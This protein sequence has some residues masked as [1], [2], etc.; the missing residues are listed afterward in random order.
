LDDLEFVTRMGDL[1]DR[2]GMDTISLSNTIG[3]AITLFERGIIDIRD[4]SGL[5]LDWGHKDTG[6]KLVH[7]T[8]RL[9]GFGKFISEGARSLGRRFAAE[10]EAIQVNGLEVAYHDPRGSSGMAL[11]YATSPRGACHN[12][13]DYF[14]VDIGQVEESLDLELYN[15]LAGAEKARNVAIHQDWRTV[16]NSLVMC[17]FANVP[18][19]DLLQLINAS[20]GNQLDLPELLL[21][22]ER[23]WNLKRMINIKLGLTPE[24]D[25]LPA[26]LLQ[27]LEDAHGEMEG[28][29][30]DFQSMLSAY[31]LAR[32]WD[33]VTGIPSAETRQQLGLSWTY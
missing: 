21:A 25:K 12:Q 1:C 13:S 11:V 5:I 20:T 31:Y 28:F 8:V 29:A 2:Y 22:G 24:D 9:E 30:P 23:A 10:P 16:Y 33:P 27:P 18:P 14:L 4:T 7:Q 3:L 6:E 17:I 32:G 15:R 19:D 26:K